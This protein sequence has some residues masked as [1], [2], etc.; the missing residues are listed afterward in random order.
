[1]S[2]TRYRF[3]RRYSCK[4]TLMMIMNLKKQK[5][6]RQ[7]TQSFCTNFENLNNEQ[8]Q[9]FFRLVVSSRIVL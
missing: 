6:R 8:F 4:R 7:N 9:I 3:K 2:I 1:M 5:Q